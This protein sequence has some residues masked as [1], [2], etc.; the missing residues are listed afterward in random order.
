M[1]FNEL[2]IRFPVRKKIYFSQEIFT[3]NSLHLFGLDAKI[4]TGS[5]TRQNFYFVKTKIK[6]YVELSNF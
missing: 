1:V 5:G 3:E 6:F 4:R 2:V